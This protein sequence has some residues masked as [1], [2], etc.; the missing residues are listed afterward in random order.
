[1]LQGEVPGFESTTWQPDYLRQHATEQSEYLD[2]VTASDVIWQVAECAM[3]LLAMSA[4]A[5]VLELGC[6]WAVV[7]VG[8]SR[9][10]QQIVSP[11]GGP[12]E[13][14]GIHVM[15]R[16]SLA[17][18]VRRIYSLDGLVSSIERLEKVS[19]LA[20]PGSGQSD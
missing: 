14:L 6:G 8:S 4:G 17:S 12:S 18:P 13:W 16:F 10:P 3:E 5:K 11:E 2:K 7:A 15:L 1:M 19:A 20:G 9:L